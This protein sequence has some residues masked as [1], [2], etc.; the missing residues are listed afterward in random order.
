MEL[1]IFLMFLVETIWL[2]T[3]NF[4]VVQGGTQQVGKS[5]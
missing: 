2:K 4:I 1:V 5:E 3:A